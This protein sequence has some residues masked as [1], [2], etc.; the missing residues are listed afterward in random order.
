MERKVRMIENYHRAYISHYCH[1][2]NDRKYSIQADAK[3]HK[4][5]FAV[6]L[7][8]NIIIILIK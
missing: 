7:K 8:I 1:L 2:D 6:L 3:L 4:K 5:L